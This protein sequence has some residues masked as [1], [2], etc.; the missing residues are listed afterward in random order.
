MCFR[1]FFTLSQNTLIR[2]L[3]IDNRKKE[4]KEKGPCGWAASDFQHALKTERGSKGC[5]GLQQGEKEIEGLITFHYSTLIRFQKLE[6]DA[7]AMEL[8]DDIFGD[9][10]KDIDKGPAVKRVKADYSVYKKSKV[11][12]QTPTVSSAWR[13][14]SNLDLPDSLGAQSVEDLHNQDDLDDSNGQPDFEAPSPD[15]EVEEAPVPE[16]ILRADPLQTST[17]RTGKGGKKSKLSF[18]PKFER[19]APIEPVLKKSDAS[20]RQEWRDVVRESVET[21][22]M[23]LSQ[24]QDTFNVNNGSDMLEEDGSLQLFWFDALEKNG[25]VYLF[26][27]V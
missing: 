25:K 21:Q 6:N 10:E 23:S 24:G 26:G 7:K 27:K 19:E 2:R 12:K 17:I 16:P 15:E 18:L 9:L 11:M 3:R 4:E 13:T 22:P 14:P 20:G 1:F 8:M 5:K